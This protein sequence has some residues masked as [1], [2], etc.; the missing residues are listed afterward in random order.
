[1]NDVYA[2]ISS[3]CSGT[4]KI[5]VNQTLE[6]FKTD[7]GRTRVRNAFRKWD[8][9]D[10]DEM[11]SMEIFGKIVGVLNVMH[12]PSQYEEVACLA[13]SMDTDELEEFERLAN[14]VIL[15]SKHIAS[16]KSDPNA[17]PDLN[18]IAWAYQTCTEMGTFQTLDRKN[19]HHPF[20]MDM[21]VQESVEECV[22]SFGGIV[23]EDVLN[24]GIERVTR[25]Y[26]GKKP[27]VTKVISIQGTHDPWKH[28]A[29]LEDYGPEAP[30]WVIDGSHCADFSVRSDDSKEVVEVREKVKKLI[31]KWF[32][33]ISA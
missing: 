29:H 10:V 15:K 1:M 7:E 5:G 21:S 17:E 8:C 18:S 33:E 4:I 6:L 28:L 26:G 20:E 9:G 31:T 19:A 13:M 22:K 3:E 32:K 11:N 30:V 23:T 12:D 25:R 14:F 24:T 27:K 2:N 16:C